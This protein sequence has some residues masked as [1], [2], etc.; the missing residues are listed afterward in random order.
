M[1]PGLPRKRSHTQKYMQKRGMILNAATAILNREGIRGMT[2]ALVADQFNIERKGI[3]YY[4]ANKDELSAA[5]FR[6][7]IT[8]YE[9]LIARAAQSP[10]P[11]QR[12][13]RLITEYFEVLGTA[14][15]GEG[16]ELARFDDVRALGNQD[17]IQAYNSMFRSVRTLFHDGSRE[18]VD[19]VALN[20]R[21][22]F[23]LQQLYWVDGWR[24]RYAPDSYADVAQRM[25]EI[26]IGGLGSNR[27]PWAP[28][29]INRVS[30]RVDPKDAHRETFLSVATRLINER[31]YR[32][33]SVDQI[34]AR[35]DVTKGSFYHHMESKDDLIAAAFARTI[36]I[37][38][39][40]QNAAQ[41]IDGDGHTRLA[42]VLAA[43][44]DR[45]LSDEVPLLRVATASVPE[46]TR[47]TI[48]ADFNRVT[49]NF[50]TMIYHGIKDGSLRLV[51]TQIAAEMTTVVIPAASELGLW[52]PDSSTNRA[53][54]AFVQLLF[55][56]VVQ[57]PQ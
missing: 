30:P 47:K 51:D 2:V 23:L 27:R 17:V 3:S 9:A 35:L 52:L 54:E 53:A 45:Q 19:R 38:R 7:T 29:P 15:R 24:T 40:A 28:A 36:E 56:G 42:A 4:F 5:C 48:L 31:G 44:V 8:Q 21:A 57:R 10:T 41:S 1:P 49:S 55:N 32:G 46:V 13:R 26:L 14:A 33:V 39:D 34:S 20:A 12:I 50:S 6:A 22:H 37:M 18:Q 16:P 43:L 25:L 11:E